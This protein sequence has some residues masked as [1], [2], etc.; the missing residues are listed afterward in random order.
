[1]TTLLNIFWLGLKEL[2]SLAS[3]IVMVIFVVYA[4]TATIYSRRPALRAKSTTPR[5]P[6]STRTVR[7]SPRSSSTPSIRRASKA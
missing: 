5:S 1:M 6:S 4:F 3:D 7:P 2:R